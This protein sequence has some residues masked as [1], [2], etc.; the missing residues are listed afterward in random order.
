MGRLVDIGDTRLYVDERGAPDAFALL[1]FHGGPGLDHHEFADYL[2]P[3]TE[4]GRYRLV[5]VDERAQGQS[6]RDVDDETVTL[7]QMAADVSLLADALGVRGSYATFGHSYGSFVTL[8][9]AVRRAGEPRGSI[10]C[11]GIA[12]RKW[13]AG[14]EREL[15]TFEP[16]ELREQVAQAWARETTIETEADA[17][18]VWLDQAPFHFKDPTGPVVA[19][20]LRRSAGTRYAPD[21]LR[22]FA[23]SD[24]GGIDV[25]DRLPEVSHPVLVLSGRYDRVCPAAAGQEMAAAIPD[26]ELVVFEDSAHMMFAEEPAKFLAVVRRFLDRVA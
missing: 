24:Y 17:E 26:A 9:H 10:V 14:I 11:G 12:A 16:V 2:D 1:V 13:L 6:D 3:L 21:V 4:D 22:R 19:D 7:E 20:Y 18:Q 5:L 25:L 15:A 8:V 23:S